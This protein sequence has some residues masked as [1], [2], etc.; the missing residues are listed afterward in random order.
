MT[1][2]QALA[3]AGLA[4]VLGLILCCF[5]FRCT[6][7]YVLFIALLVSLFAYPWLKDRSGLLGN[8]LVAGFLAFPAVFAALETKTPGVLLLGG[9]T[10]GFGFSREI[11]K[12]LEDRLGDRQY[13]RV[14][15][16]VHGKTNW[17][18][19]LVISGVLAGTAFWLSFASA[20]WSSILT[21]ALELLL[22]LP[23]GAAALWWANE[24]TTTRFKHVLK[25][26]MFAAVA[27]VLF[28]ARR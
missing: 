7:S 23:V 25:V 26:A 3:V 14:T 4:A 20:V 2:K 27:L 18:V 21:V 16:A 10:A 15:I 28:C 13:G 11:L 19:W 9:L 22:C 6:W 12:D 5:A 24:L 1:D 17:V 8:L